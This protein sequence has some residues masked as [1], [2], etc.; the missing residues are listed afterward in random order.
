MFIVGEGRKSRSDRK[1][2]QLQNDSFYRES[3]TS[4]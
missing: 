1:K 2:L 4:G 3:E